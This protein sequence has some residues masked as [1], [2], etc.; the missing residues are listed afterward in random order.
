MR[1]WAKGLAFALVLAVLLMVAVT[2]VRRYRSPNAVTVLESAVMDMGAMKAPTGAAPVE[3]ALVEEGHLVP[4]V[5]Y[6][7]TVIAQGDQEIAARVTGVVQEVL[8]YPGDRVVPG[9]LLVRL[10]SA[11]LSA[12][13]AE[14][15]A[16]IV[17]QESQV[18]ALEA[19]RSTREAEA[20]VAGVGVP[21]AGADIETSQETVRAAQVALRAMEAEVGRSRTLYT[22]GGISL[23]ELQQDEARLA[24]TRADLKES[25]QNLRKASLSRNQAQ[26]QAE[27]GRQQVEQANR[28]ISSGQASVERERAALRSTEVQLGYTEIRATQLGEVTERVA[29]PGTLVSPGQVVLRVKQS[30]SVRLQAAVPVEQ[31]GGIRP[32]FAV[33]ARVGE[34]TFD[35]T[36]SAVFGQA[37]PQTR[38]I[39]VEAKTFPDPT[40]VP[41]AYSSME[42]ATSE[43]FH[44]LSIPVAA[45]Q[46]SLDGKDFVWKKIP[47]STDPVIYTCVMHPEVMRPSPGDCPKCGMKLVPAKATGSG[48]AQKQVVGVGAVI[49]ERV[50]IRQG[51]AKD[52]VVITQGGRGLIE[53]M[54]VSEVPW[55]KE[56]VPQ[57]EAPPSAPKTPQD[58]GGGHAGH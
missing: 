15:R 50:V 39:I 18:R 13:A 22:N 35:T 56:G 33:K 55:S 47:S 30:G 4:T 36:V 9:Q 20:R 52:D 57:L 8:V 53:G 37:D 40:L 45:L 31:A 34:K 42:I 54:T 19:E 32:G 7:G 1:N 28:G 12:R 48:V 51:L 10:D 29:S 16:A 26:A 11:E 3:T 23:E 5:T 38:T 21:L 44:G 27:A 41:G 24:Q 17:E 46:R 2:V 25:Q 6:P 58:H 49:G 43:G 14:A